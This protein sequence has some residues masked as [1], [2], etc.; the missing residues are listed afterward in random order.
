M[1]FLLPSHGDAP[2]TEF[3]ASPLKYSFYWRGKSEAKLEANISQSVACKHT[4]HRGTFQQNV[5]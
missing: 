2:Q 3:P 4:E 1:T 5:D